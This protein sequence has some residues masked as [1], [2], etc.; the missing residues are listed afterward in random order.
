MCT[1][2]SGFNLYSFVLLIFSVVPVNTLRLLFMIIIILGIEQ[3][4]LMVIKCN[5]EFNFCITFKIYLIR[6]LVHFLIGNLTEYFI[7]IL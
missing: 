1:K 4:L 3:V 7:G 5:L 6:K 2:M